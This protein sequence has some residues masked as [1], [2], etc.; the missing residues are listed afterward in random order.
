MIKNIKKSLKYIIIIVGTI[1]ILPTILYLLLQVSE[2]QTYLANRITAHFSKELKSTISVGRIEY[3]FFNRL[4]VNDILVKDQHNDTL[5]YSQKFIAGIRRLNFKN[6]TYKLGRVVLVKPVV[7]LITDSTGM[8]NLTWYIDQ[9]KNPA[10]T[11]KKANSLFSVDQIDLSDARFSLINK[12]KPRSKQEIDFNN[13]HLSS[14]NGIIEDFKVA[15]DTTAFNIYNL[16]LKESGGF[17]VKRMSSSVKLANRNILFSS[18]YLGCDSSII[19]I[20]KLELTPAPVH[21]SLSIADKSSGNLKL[22]LQLEKSLI[23]SSD[24]QHFL[25]YVSSVNESVWLSGKV[26]GTI[27][28]LRGRN[29]QLHYRDNTFLDCDFDFSG[30]PD[31]ENAFVFIDVN[32]LRTNAK[33]IEK[34]NI[35]GKGNLIIPDVLY[36]LGNISFDGSFTGFL[37]DF[38]T[39]GKIRTKYGN[40][41]TDISIRPEKHDRYKVKGLMAMSDVNLGE[42]T[43]KTELLGKISMQANIDGYANSLKKFSVNLSGNVDSVEIKQY[44]YRNITLKG[45]FTEKTWDGS[46]NINDKNISMDLLGMLNFKEDLPEFDFTL[47]VAKANL[48]KLNIDKP[49]TTSSLT[50]LM[51]ANF[52]G[53]SIDNLDGEIKLLNST[54]KKYNNSL[55]MYDF[56]LRTYKEK[57][58]PVLSLRTD[59]IDADIK[60]DYNFSAIKALYESILSSLMPSKFHSSYSLSQFKKESFTFDIDFKN[61]DRINDFFRTGLMIAEKSHIRGDIFPDSVISIKGRS[62]MLTIKNNVFNDF[63]LDAT[64]S[65]PDL[66]VNLNSSSLAVLRQSELKGIS[67]NLSTKPDNFIFTADWDN[68]EKSV[69]RGNLVIRGAFTKS[70]DKKRSAILKIDID[71]TDIYTRNNLWKINKS[72]ITV[73]SNAVKIDRIYFSNNKNYYL[74]DGA[75][76]EDPSDTLNLEFKGIDISPLNYLINP[77]NYNDTSRLHLD[78]KGRL[79]GKVLLTNVY[80]DLLLE[81][82]IKVNNL[83][84]LNSQFGDLAIVSDWDIAT[85]VININAWNDLAGARTLNIKG[86]YDPGIK[87][88]KLT[89]ETKKQP[90]DFLNPLLKSFASDIKGT[91]SG[92]VNFTAGSNELILEGAVKTEEASIKVDYLQTRYILNDSA[93]FNREG[94]KFNNFKFTDEKDNSATL[95]GT[96]YHKNFKDFRANLTIN[97]NQ[98]LVLNTK[99]KD[100]ELFY[101]TVYASGVTTIKTEPNSLSFDI[102]AKTGKNTKF[103]IPMNTGLSVSEYSFISFV[104]ADTAKGKTHQNTNIRIP[105]SSTKTGVD[106]NFELEVTPEAEVQLIFDSKVG[107]QMRG[108]GSGKLNLSLNKKGDFRISGDYDIDEGD[109]LFTLGNILNKSFSVEN[110]GKIIF[111]GDLDNAEID[112]Q[113]IY[114]LKASLYEILQDDNYKDR[115]PVDCQLNLSGN[116]FNPVVGFNIYLPNADEETRTYLRNAISTEEDLSRQFLYLLVMNS[117]YADQSSLTSSNSTTTAGPSAMAVTT[118]EMLSNQLSNWLS[119]ISNDFDIGFAYRPG[120]SD[121]NPQEVQLALSTQLLNDKVVINGNFDVRGTGSSADNTDQITG[122]FDASVR[123]TDRIRFKVFNRFNNPYTGRGVPYTQGIGIFFKQDFDKFSD[124]LRKKARPEVKKTE[125]KK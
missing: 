73:D 101:G 117:F 46:I 95:S 26:F 98:C 92:K 91:I 124:L 103:F 15:N 28:E 102:S 61:T 19:N 79:N 36:K 27:A 3:K 87:K 22:D 89:A 38:V 86:I 44:E 12:S 21:D 48:H 56:S 84:L 24:L 115:I 116:L 119:Q 72:S 30:L 41:R 29:I 17:S 65:G 123:I 80:R 5:L 8:M 70:Q 93:R 63:S 109:Y 4:S 25:P 1:I 49:D 76:S 120:Y 75:L 23:N 71:S 97:T 68:K 77:K 47:N 13:L 16:G 110:G 54:L 69:T 114:K 53:N 50:M 85:K 90:V 111:N 45:I 32:R 82:N 113:A 96:V 88:I 34:L 40:I 39:Y 33:D 55:D 78:L 43:N 125:K 2:V 59:F 20:V 58:K 112:L 18:A 62:K 66:S 6:N 104:D 11:L 42:L 37:T 83:S 35:P 67:V 118:T 74:V 52:K 10:D 107:D 57:N 105:E 51:T 121:I 122:D 7:A 100:N 31:I 81:T 60:G 99:A 108:H 94:I 14:I 64:V 9:L 106:L